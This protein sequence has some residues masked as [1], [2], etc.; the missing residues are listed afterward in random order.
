ML[1]ANSTLRRPVAMAPEMC[2]KHPSGVRRPVPTV[3]HVVSAVDAASRTDH[4]AVIFCHGRGEP[5]CHFHGVLERHT[6]VHTLCLNIR[7]SLPLHGRRPTILWQ[8][9]AIKFLTRV[10]R[11][12]EAASFWTTLMLSTA[13]YSLQAD[14]VLVHCDTG[15]FQDQA[16]FDGAFKDVFPDSLRR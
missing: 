7:V 5:D 9:A 8:L 1:H 15:Y 2:P 4:L 16:E 11:S 6:F 13:P 12:V 14:S 3:V 10:H